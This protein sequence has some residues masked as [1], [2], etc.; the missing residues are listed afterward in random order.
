MSLLQGGTSKERKYSP[1]TRLASAMVI[2]HQNTTE[3]KRKGHEVQ[4]LME[5][6]TKL[7]STSEI[8]SQQDAV[9][10]N[11]KGGYRA[12]ERRGNTAILNMHMHVRTLLKENDL[13]S[14]SDEADKIKKDFTGLCETYIKG[15]HW[16]YEKGKTE[17]NCF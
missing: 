11:L 7:D 2:G 1:T 6:K 3:N 4:G 5:Q 15:G 12:D 13:D 16:M 17:N 14:L 10:F 8:R 9:R